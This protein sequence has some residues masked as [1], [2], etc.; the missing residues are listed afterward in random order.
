MRGQVRRADRGEWARICGE[1][2]PVGGIPLRSSGGTQE[3]YSLDVTPKRRAL[4]APLLSVIHPP[5]L[6]NW[7]CAFIILLPCSFM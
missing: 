5:D 4:I 2:E 3:N 7:R 6:R 1:R